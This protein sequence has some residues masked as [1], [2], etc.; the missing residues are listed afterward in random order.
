[1]TGFD[2]GTGKGAAFFNNKRRRRRTTN[3]KCYCGANHGADQKL[4]QHLYTGKCKHG[5]R[6]MEEAGL[7]SYTGGSG[8]DVPGKT[9]VTKEYPTVA[10]FLKGIK[11]VRIS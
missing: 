7:Q 10:A 8:R 1:M 3:Y 5:T 6:M 4:W 9:K 11:S 2:R